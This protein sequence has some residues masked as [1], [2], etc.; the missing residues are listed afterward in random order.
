MFRKFLLSFLKWIW[1]QADTM[2]A[3]VL[4][5][6]C[7]VL[8]LFGAAPLPLLISATL[9]TLTVLAIALMRDRLDREMTQN[10]LNQLLLQL[11]DPLPERLFKYD[12]DQTPLWRGRSIVGR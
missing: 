11:D 1:N 8:G 9:G 10:R 3:L 5:A 6:T 2:L 7:S 4:A 12:I